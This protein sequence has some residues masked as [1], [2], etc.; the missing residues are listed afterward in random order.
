MAQ[1]G[2]TPL[3]LYYSATAS[4]A[5]LAANL[6]SGELALNTNDGKLYYKDS[7]GVVQVLATKASSSGSFGALTATSITNSGLTSGRVVY[8][9]T[10]GLETTSAN[11]VFD[12]TN[13]GIGTASGTSKLDVAKASSDTITRANS[14]TALGDFASLGA[15]LLMQQT[16]SSPYGFALQAADATN[17]SRFPLLLNPSGGNVG[18]GTSSP[19]YKLDVTGSA[20]ITSASPLWL[21]TTTGDSYIQYGASATTANNWT[22]G[23]QGDGT[24][25]FFNGTYS[26]GTERMC[27]TSAGNVG[28]GTSSP[29][30]NLQIGDGTSAAYQIVRIVGAN[31]DLYIGQVPAVRFGLTSGTFASVYNDANQALAMGTTSAYPLVFG[32]NNAERMRITSAG[33]VQILSSSTSSTFTNSG[34]L[35]IKN[36]A[37]TPYIS[38]HT[39]VGARLSYLQ[40]QTIGTELNAE[41][42]YLAFSTNAERMRIDTSGNVLVGTTS[43]YN[44]ISNTQ[45][46]ISASDTAM[47]VMGVTSIAVGNEVSRIVMG[48]SLGNNRYNSISTFCPAGAA[49][50][51]I[52][53][54]RFST[55]NGGSSG[56][57]E[58]MRLTPEGNLL[59]G[60]T[61][62]SGSRQNF[63]IG[64]N[65]SGSSI[66]MGI[67]GTNKAT[68]QVDSGSDLYIENNA[69][70]RVYVVP[71]TNGVYLAN[72]GVAWIANSDERLKE[73]LLPITDAVNKVSTLRAVTGNYISDAD[74]KS[75]AFLIAQDV[76]AVLP[77]AVDVSDLEKLGVSYT[78]V[79]PLLVAAIKELKSEIDLLKGK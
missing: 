17:T 37:N 1:S 72:G 10:G 44:P 79:I 67:S 3:S 55:I 11:F 69:S 57:T 49:G 4:T 74:K 75:R 47:L 33:L 63:R 30:G 21:G 61:T 73:N 16:L 26:S 20:R 46:R 35:A 38:W 13:V 42:G 23:S 14:V 41:T 43:S 66:T 53:D 60:A 18:I 64:G 56:P 78:D 24:F 5:P 31:S 6:V 7:S 25:R 15:G 62:A 40:A 45:V 65:A 29:F 58:R 36:S 28:I 19:A 50:S 59:V 8:T 27:I 9:T 54:M 51:D 48:G 68:I 12:G 77:E 32:T 71:T 39:S 2:Y 70:G 76:Q 34:E 52:L 22:I